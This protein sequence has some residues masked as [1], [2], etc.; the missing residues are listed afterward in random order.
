MNNSTDFRKNPQFHEN[1]SSDPELFHAD[2]RTDWTDKHDEANIRLS[3]FS[4]SA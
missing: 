2:V 3:P 4:E 1:Q